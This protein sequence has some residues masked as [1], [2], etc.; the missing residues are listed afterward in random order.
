MYQ[1]FY[2]DEL[3]YRKTQTLNRRTFLLRV[4]YIPLFL[5]SFQSLVLLK[6]HYNVP[7][8]HGYVLI[9]LDLFFQDKKTHSAQ[10]TT[11]PMIVDTTSTHC[12]PLR[13]ALS[14][15]SSTAPTDL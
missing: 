6:K 10:P 8:W 9:I 5:I 15:A 11:Q 14:R 3:N 4:L 13:G 1:P 7:Y 12:A 2:Y